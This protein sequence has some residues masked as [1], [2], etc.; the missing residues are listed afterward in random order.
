LELGI[1]ARGHGVLSGDEWR[2]K[3]KGEAWG[4]DDG[5]RRGRTAADV[6]DVRGQGGCRAC[7][8]RKMAAAGGKERGEGDE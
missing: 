8:M 5:R 2:K 6:G 1:F 3:N 7:E 4:D